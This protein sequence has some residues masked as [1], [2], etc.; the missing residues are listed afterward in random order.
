MLSILKKHNKTI[1][2]IENI[3]GWE[4]YGDYEFLQINI[5]II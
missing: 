3:K 1:K 4:Y 5:M 2:N